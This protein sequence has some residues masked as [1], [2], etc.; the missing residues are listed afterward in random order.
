MPDYPKIETAGEASLIV[1][2]AAEASPDSA[3]AVRSLGDALRERLGEH[4]EDLIPAHASLL[5]IFDAHA[6]NHAAVAGELREIIARLQQ[7]RTEGGRLVQIPVYYAPES[8]EDIEELGR[9]SGLGWEGVAELHASREYQ[10]YAIGFA[11]GFAYL[12]DVDDRIAR[13]RLATPRPRVPRGAVAIA[14]RQTAVYPAD[15]PGGWN[16]I[17]RSPMT[18]FNAD[19]D[20]ED[21][22]MVLRA[23]DRVRF[24]PVDRDEFEALGGVL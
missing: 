19:A 20:S 24:R 5:V 4:I 2:L 21:T 8:G 22:A 14:E 13:P 9:S 6:T 17:G 1:Y 12:G 23:G 15:S 7:G 11:P 10:V 3:A 18:L 16:L